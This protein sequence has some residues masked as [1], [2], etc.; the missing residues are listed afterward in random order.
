MSPK[1]SEQWLLDRYRRHHDLVAREELVRRMAPL[2]RRVATAYNARG[3]EDDLMQV[4]SLGLTK[5]IDR[6]DPA[7]GVPLR[8]YA[9]PTMYGEVRRYLRDHSWAMRV[10]R[11]LQER[12]LAVTKCVDGLVSREGRSPT[13]ERIA[14]ELDLELEEVLEAL[15]AGAAYAA[16]S[17]EAP[18]GRLDDGERTVADTIGFTDERLELAEEVADLR[19][20]GSVLDD[21]DRTVLYLR[22]MRDMTQ[23]EIAQE[24]GC[25]QMQVSRILRKALARLSETANAPTPTPTPALVAA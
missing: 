17:L 9:I 22:F 3:H 11:P 24:I 13:P 1:I 21:R 8:T 5:A 7:F 14:Q 12:V 19:Q 18:A 23:T 10:P 2:V 20:L 4:A 6:Y 15:E 16:T 25:S